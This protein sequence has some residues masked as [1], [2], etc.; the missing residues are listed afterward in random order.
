EEEVNKSD[1]ICAA[2]EQSYHTMHSIIP[3]N[4]EDVVFVARSLSTKVWR[5]LDSSTRQQCSYHDLPEDKFSGFGTPPYWTLSLR[6]TPGN[7]MS[8]AAC[9]FSAPSPLVL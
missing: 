3:C 2:V 8:G 5:V 9:D 1:P 7:A 4:F 6:W